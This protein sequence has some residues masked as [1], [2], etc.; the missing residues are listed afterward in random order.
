MATQ[1]VIDVPLHRL[2]VHEGCQF[3]L[4]QAWL[5]F[6]DINRDPVNKP[7]SCFAKQTGKVWI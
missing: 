6:A 4:N 7:I 5:I 3:A 1:G 2:L